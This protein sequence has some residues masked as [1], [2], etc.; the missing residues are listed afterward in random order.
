MK[1]ALKVAAVMFWLAAAHSGLAA[2]YRVGNV[3]LNQDDPIGKVL[4]ALGQPMSKE[5]VQNRY[6][7]QIGENWYYRDGRKTVKITISG[8][9][10]VDIEEIRD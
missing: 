6:G 9:R 7:A 2:T 1:V 10:I 3:V 5:S 8:G 4:D